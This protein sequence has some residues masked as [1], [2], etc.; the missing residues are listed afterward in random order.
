VR[1]LEAPWLLN[2]IFLAALRLLSKRVLEFR[3]GVEHVCVARSLVAVLRSAVRQ[4]ENMS[5]N[6]WVAERHKCW[7]LVVC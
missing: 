4:L 7:T 2:I 3:L 1:V 6:L 5:Q